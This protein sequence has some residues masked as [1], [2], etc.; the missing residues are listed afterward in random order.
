M[1]PRLHGDDYYFLALSMA[2]RKSEAISPTAHYTGQVWVRNGLAD[3]GFDTWQGRVL[4]QALR[5][6]LAIYG[7]SGGPSLESVLLARHQIIDHLLEQAIDEGRVSQVIEVAAGLSPRGWRFKKKYGD[8]VTYLEADLPDMAAAKRSLLQRMDFTPAG[9]RVVDIDAL[10]DDGPQ[11]LAALAESL[12][13]RQGLAII[14]EGLLN[15]F[16]RDAV[17]GMW[18]RFAGVLA[19]F[20]GGLYLSDLHLS[21]ENRGAAIKGFGRI[22]STFVRGRIHMHFST[23][24]EAENELVSAGFSDALLHSPTDFSAVLDLDDDPAHRLVRVITARTGL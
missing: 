6:T 4:Y 20:S 18:R 14:T 10:A 19:D 13:T 3:K 8:A 23:A 15:Y 7:L 17:L 21:G 11:S 22:L 24:L 12:D 2:S 16:D 9:H 5:P 1:D